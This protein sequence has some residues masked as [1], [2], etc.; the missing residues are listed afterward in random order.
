MASH[1]KTTVQI[2]DSLFNEARKVARK[3]HTT[4]KALI[5]TGLRRVIAE[6]SQRERFKLRKATFK[7]KGLQPHLAGA[8]WDQLRDISYEGRGG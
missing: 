2:P 3:K 6:H 4:M 8:S 5:E 7:G 1:M